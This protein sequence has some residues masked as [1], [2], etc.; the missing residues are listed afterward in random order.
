LPVIDK[1]KFPIS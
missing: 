1:G